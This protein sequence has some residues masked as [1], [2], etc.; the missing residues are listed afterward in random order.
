[1][2]HNDDIW[3]CIRGNGMFTMSIK[4]LE[5]LHERHKDI[6]LFAS[7]VTTNAAAQVIAIKKSRK[8]NED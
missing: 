2:E 5:A 1:M 7:K 6:D 8:I 4:E 3:A